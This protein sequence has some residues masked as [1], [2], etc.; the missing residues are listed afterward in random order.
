MD[1]N[2]VIV[3]AEKV[4]RLDAN[5]CGDIVHSLMLARSLSKVIRGL[6]KLALDEDHKGLAR[7]ALKNLG[8]SS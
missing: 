1:K 3:F 6:D 5:A 2:D 8:F 7:Q 4:S